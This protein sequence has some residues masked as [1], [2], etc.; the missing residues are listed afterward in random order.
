MKAIGFSKNLPIHDPESLVD[1]DIAPP[2]L[3][4]RDLLV[5]VHAISVNPIDVKVRSGLYP[6]VGSPTII[7]WDVAGV[8]KAVGPEVTLFSPGDK[9]FYAGDLTRPGANSELHA[10]DERIVGRMPSSLSFAQ[11][12]ALPLTSITAWELL[13]DRLEVPK[14]HTAAPKSILV[15]GAAGGVGSILIQLARTMTNLTIIATASRPETQEWV[16]SLGADIV[17]DHNKSMSQQLIA[18]GISQVDYV[19]G[20]NNS[21]LHLDEI[22][23]CL[24][25]QGKFGLIDD[26]E[27][28]AV[29]KLKGKSL[30]LHWE[31]M[32]T[33]S[34]HQTTDMIEQHNLLTHI[35]T[36]VDANKINTTLSSTFGVINAENLRKAH[37]FIESG[38]AKGKIVLEGF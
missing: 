21:D 33:R 8:V 32:F 25:P 28:L 34:M 12:A 26:P 18:A 22:V 24:V 19:A 29:S 30:S 37:A 38:K 10:V 17:I 16:K 5:E 6:G 14:S 11:A 13:F 3:A 7:G 1:L 2:L 9:V 35:A 20:L 36:L 31:L 4:A 23:E 27:S 15:V